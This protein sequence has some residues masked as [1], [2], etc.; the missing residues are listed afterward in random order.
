MFPPADLVRTLAALLERPRPEQRLEG[1]AELVVRVLDAPFGAAVLARAGGDVAQIAAP[2]NR[3]PAPLA[4]ALTAWLESGWL[5]TVALPPG[6]AR[7][8]ADVHPQHDALPETLVTAHVGA[9][10]VAAFPVGAV[11]GWL[12]AG[13]DPARQPPDAVARARLE[14]LAQLAAALLRGETPPAE[15]GAAALLDALPDPIEVYNGEGRLVHVNRR[16]EAVFGVGKVRPGMSEETVAAALQ[17][18]FA[19]PDRLADA[20]RRHDPTPVELTMLGADPLTFERFAANVPDRADA[21]T[22]VVYRDVTRLKRIER[23]KDEF[24][25]LASHEL[26]TP[27]TTIKGYSQ[28][29][30]RR[31]RNAVADP[32]RAATLNLARAAD[33]ADQIREEGDRLNRLVDQ[34]LDVSRIQTGRL[35]MN[36]QPLDL[37]VLLHEAVERLRMAV[38]GRTLVYSAPRERLPLMVSADADR[39]K[40]VL[41]N[42]V[43]NA[44]RYSPPESPV[45]VRLRVVSTASAAGRCALLTVRDQ[46]IGIEQADLDR[47]FDRFYRAERPAAVRPLGMGL[48]L[49]ITREIVHKHGGRIWAESAGPGKGAA[50]HVELPLLDSAR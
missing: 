49:F 46:G 24:L 22:V 44:M 4:A 32:A 26:K 38:D 14:A 3:T 35:T 21:A 15:D 11:S 39:L 47:I 16:H 43:E 42:L 34:L 8:L 37:R 41:G 12:I 18:V 2:A 33:E 6:Q 50:L 29:L 13:T 31:L 5:R 27:L 48:G 20:A 19:E 30:Q 28:M 17:P 9:A 25:S 10:L 1:V 40:Q 36:L 23:Q 45:E 7:V